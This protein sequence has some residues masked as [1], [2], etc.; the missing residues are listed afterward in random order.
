MDKTVCFLRWKHTFWRNSFC[1]FFLKNC[2]FLAA[3]ATKIHTLSICRCPSADNLSIGKNWTK[4]PVDKTFRVCFV[5]WDAFCPG[6]NMPWTHFVHLSLPYRLIICPFGQKLDKIPSG[7]NIQGL[8]CPLGHVLS[9][10]G[11]TDKM[12]PDRFVVDKTCPGC[13]LSTCRCP[14]GR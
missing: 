10:A 1:F 14:I 7:Q 8:F 6:Q 13:I 4:Y 3:N 5:H 11:Q 2:L 12:R 9:K